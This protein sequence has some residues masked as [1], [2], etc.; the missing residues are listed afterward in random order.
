MNYRMDKW[1]RHFLRVARECALLSKDP[2]SQIGAVI[3]KDRRII[4]TGFNGFPP[5][6][7][8]DRRLHDR[9]EKLKLVV[10]AEANALLDAGRGSKGATLYMFGFQ[11]APCDN[12]TKH[13]IAAGITRVVGGGTLVPERWKANLAA[14]E[15]T[16]REAGVAFVGYTMGEILDGPLV[17]HQERAVKV[18]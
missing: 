8:D 12:C 11:S 6:I 2:S 1:D 7:A 9:E 16:L 5:G 14:S 10:H 18:S 3:V 17:T 4:S 15:E 13:V